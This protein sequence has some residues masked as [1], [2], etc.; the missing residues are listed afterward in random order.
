VDINPPPPVRFDGVLLSKTVTDFL[1]SN[2]RR[3]LIAVCFLLGNSPA[4]EV[5]VPTFQNTLFHLHRQVG[6]CRITHT[7][8]PMKMERTECF[9]TSAYKRQTPGNYPE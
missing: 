1:I 7:Y 6:V 3:V 5:Y 2:I 9:E 4:S 8:L